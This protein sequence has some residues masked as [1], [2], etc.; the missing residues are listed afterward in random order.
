MHAIIVAVLLG[1]TMLN[2]ALA[3]EPMRDTAAPQV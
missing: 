2:S 3:P 1:Y